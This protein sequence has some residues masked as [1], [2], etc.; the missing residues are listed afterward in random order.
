MVCQTCK[1]WDYGTGIKRH[2]SIAG[3]CRKLPPPWPT[4]FADD[5]C[6]EYGLANMSGVPNVPTPPPPEKQPKRHM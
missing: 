1:W 4:V 5:W 6:G 3:K 2:E